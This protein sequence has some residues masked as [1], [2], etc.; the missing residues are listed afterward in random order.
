[1]T[2]PSGE[3]GGVMSLLGGFL[4]RAFLPVVAAIGAA[5]VAMAP[6]VGAAL[7]AA[8]A[9]VVAAWL[10]K[11]A[12]DVVAPAL[13]DARNNF[14][15]GLDDVNRPMFAPTGQV[16]DA[17]GR[18]INDPRRTDRKEAAGPDGRALNDPRRTDLKKSDAP[19]APS[20]SW[21]ESLGRGAGY[22]KNGLESLG[23]KP[24]DAS[25]DPT[26]QQYRDRV[27]AAK[28]GK[29]LG[30]DG[31]QRTYQNTDGSIESRTGGT[32]AWRNNNPGNMEYGDFARSKGAIGSDGRFAV[33]PDYQSGRAAKESLIFE[34]GRYKDL[35]L[36]DAISRY[37]P[38][39]ENNT[40][41]YQNSVLASVGGQNKRMADFT[42]A[43]RT[44]ILDSMQRVEGYRVGSVTNAGMRMPA[45]SVLTT[46][47][48][49]LPKI[50]VV[51]GAIPEKLAPMPQI[52]IPE[53]STV[54]ERPISVSSNSLVGQNVS[55]RT[56]AH[57]AS[58]GIGSGGNWG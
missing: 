54:K 44:A 31:T 20:N 45:S 12:A 30:I 25:N 51:T 32:L 46:S 21:S 56:I 28:V 33:F 39:S 11:K 19:L 6:V 3:D 38:P 49:A 58:G 43:E 52:S 35:S 17:S 24:V 9:A 26:S 14:N 42:A 15:R 16:L 23:F 36:K 10:V 50:P 27:N 37:A 29:V 48:L 57:A 41:A 34:G 55:D 47:G 13:K 40:N 2:G 18:D 4:G 53:P 7:A 5:I 22:V 8:V 1:M